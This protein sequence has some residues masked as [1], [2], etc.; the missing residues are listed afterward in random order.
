MSGQLAVSM[1]IGQLMVAALS[2]YLCVLRYS[3]LIPQVPSFTM[4]GGCIENGKLESY[5]PLPAVTT[6]FYRW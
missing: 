6:A 4:P 2:E 5:K 1:R 3:A